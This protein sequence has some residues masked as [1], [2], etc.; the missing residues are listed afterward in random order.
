[1]GPALGA[2]G[3]AEDLRPSPGGGGDKDAWEM[4]GARGCIPQGEVLSHR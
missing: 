2:E 1:M 3:E 4:W